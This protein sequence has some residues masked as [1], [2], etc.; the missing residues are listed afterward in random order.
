MS[1][2]SS[3]ARARACFVVALAGLA[4][5]CAPGLSCE[6][7]PLGP[8]GEPYEG[9]LTLCVSD[10]VGAPLPDVEV[11]DAEVLLGATDRSGQLVVRDPSTL[12]LRSPGRL[13]HALFGSPSERFGLVLVEAPDAVETERVAVTVSFDEALPPAPSDVL[14]LT[15]VRASVRLEA[16]AIEGAAAG[17]PIGACSPGGLSCTATVRVAP[18]TRAISATVLDLHPDGSREVHRIGSVVRGEG[19]RLELS[20][21]TPAAFVEL[22]D[23][24]LDA[25][26]GV[27]GLGV[28]GQVVFFGPVAAA[29][30]V[31]LPSGES[32]WVALHLDADAHSVGVVQRPASGA[33]AAPSAPLVELSSGRLM[34]PAGNAMMHTLAGYADGAEVWRATLVGRGGDAPTFA[35][36]PDGLDE[37]VVAVHGAPVSGPLTQVLGVRRLSIP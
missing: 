12:T 33:V 9:V 27:P 32:P 28:D 7:A 25:V 16:G 4:F 37:L 15:E 5:G 35:D 26:V 22:T 20:V 23:L 29:E 30:P 8:S 6:D 13:P 21:S 1:G 2:T 36:L 31:P 19:N 14:R 18:D 11:F 3:G 10:E 34:L 24:P 17:A